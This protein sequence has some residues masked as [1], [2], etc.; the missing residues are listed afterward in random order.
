[1]AFDLCHLSSEQRSGP[2]N[3][4]PTRMVKD[5]K[6]TACLNRLGQSVVQSGVAHVPFTIK[7]EVSDNTVSNLRPE[8]VRNPAIVACIDLLG[9]NV[10]RNS[11]ARIPVT[12]RI[13]P[14]R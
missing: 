14:A 13:V 11:N 1:M 12:I 7:L 3:R 10:V 8:V 4:Q 2:G 6:L 5:T 9:Q